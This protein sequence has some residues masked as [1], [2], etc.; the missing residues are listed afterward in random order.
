[1]TRT[2]SANETLHLLQKA[3]VVFRHWWSWPW[4][5]KVIFWVFFM[6]SMLRRNEGKE[7]SEPSQVR[8]H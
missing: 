6:R 1:M 4:P 7:G 5:L 2:E 3:A 8:F